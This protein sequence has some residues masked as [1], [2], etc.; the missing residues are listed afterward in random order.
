MRW[1]TFEGVR[2]D[3]R[4][5]TQKPLI[6]DLIE[7]KKQAGISV[8]TIADVLIGMGEMN[9]ILDVYDEVDRLEVFAAMLFLCKRKAGEDYTWNDALSVSLIDITIEFDEEEGEESDPKDVSP[10]M[11]D[12][13]AVEP[14][15]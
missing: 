15:T 4:E 11:P 10:S 8:R 3:L 6:R 9:S 2:Y 5:A 1:L 12:G 13:D 7:L 14:T